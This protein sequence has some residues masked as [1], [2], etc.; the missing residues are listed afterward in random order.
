[1]AEMLWGSQREIVRGSAVTAV[2]LGR[3]NGDGSL[4]VKS[5]QDP[6][7]RGDYLVALP[8]AAGD[9]TTVA[10]E[11]SHSHTVPGLRG[12]RPGDWVLVAW[13][14]RDPVIAAIVVSS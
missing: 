11:Y 8:L 5:I 10:G 12:L 2:E 14:G 7:P 6:I 4:S 3:V 1:M 9:S 13:A